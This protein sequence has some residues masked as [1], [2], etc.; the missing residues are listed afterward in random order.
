MTTVSYFLEQIQIGTGNNYTTVSSTNTKINNVVGA[1]TNS[2]E[3]GN[4]ITMTHPL[5]TVPALII[6]QD[7]TTGAMTINNNLDMLDNSIINCL[8][9]NNNS[10]QNL[11]IGNSTGT[12]TV[13]SNT[14]FD[15]GLS[16]G[17]NQN[18]T[19][20]SG[21]ATTP[22]PTLGQLGYLYP[23]TSGFVAGTAVV[24]AST[25]YAYTTLPTGGTYAVSGF[26]TLN[27]TSAVINKF[28]VK[29]LYDADFKVAGAN[30]NI[31]FGTPVATS[32][33]LSLTVSGIV[34]V[35]GG[36]TV[37]FWASLDKS[38]GTSTIGIGAIGANCAMNIIRIA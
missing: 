5:A 6:N 37:G 16:L 28:E 10:G 20:N 30:T 31:S 2:I 38:S 29:I 14:T 18:I 21:T 33:A 12:I 27:N 34:Q 22:S 3:V 1:N 7:A 19:L 17:T 36:T 4:G 23:L 35:V 24:L 9:I 13:L 11:S 25:L 26:F 15:K 32:N 8:A